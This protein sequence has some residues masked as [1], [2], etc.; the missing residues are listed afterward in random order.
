MIGQNA[1]TKNDTAAFEGGHHVNAH[2]NHEKHDV[3]VRELTVEEM[4]LISGGCRS[5]H[6]P[7]P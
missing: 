4:Y 1:K 3:L 6:A 2:P 5:C 7:N